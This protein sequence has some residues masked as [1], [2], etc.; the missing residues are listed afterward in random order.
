MEND[1]KVIVVCSKNKAKND[2]VKN[3]M[4][5][6]FDEFEII[7][8]NTNSG[9]SE[10]PIGDEEGI[11]GCHNRIKDAINSINEKYKYNKKELENGKIDV[12]HLKK[13]QK[14]HFYVDGPLY[15]IE[16]KMNTI[17]DAVLK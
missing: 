15:I 6:F 10:T 13:H 4:K 11:E 3:V 5:Q 8:L 16:Q 9:V 12:E 1:K 2:A 7:S 17:M 14:E